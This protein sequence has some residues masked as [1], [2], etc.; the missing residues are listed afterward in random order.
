M[1]KLYLL[2]F[3]LLLHTQQQF[4]SHIPPLLDEL[5][6][7]LARHEQPLTAY[8]IS[9]LKACYAYD[10][11]GAVRN[12]W[13]LEIQN[14]E[15]ETLSF[16]LRSHGFNE[17]VVD[18][19]DPKFLS[20]LFQVVAATHAYPTPKGKE[21]INPLEAFIQKECNI[22]SFDRDIK[23]P[24]EIEQ[25]NP[26]SQGAGLRG[27]GSSWYINFFSWIYCL[28]TGK[29]RTDCTMNM[30][31]RDPLPSFMECNSHRAIDQEEVQP[32]IP[33]Q[34]ILH[35]MLSLNGDEK[36]ILTHKPSRGCVAISGDYDNHIPFPSHCNANPNMS[37][38]LYVSLY[39]SKKL[40]VKNIQPYSDRLIKTDSTPNTLFKNIFD[41]AQL[42]NR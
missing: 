4:T 28:I 37:K 2:L 12:S 17:H 31:T 36:I 5:A 40:G 11:C 9:Y 38:K 35:N 26:R 16:L 23:L 24:E 33:S 10:M 14:T 6:K 41:Q 13:A 18:N 39:S 27:A 21:T 19:N 34:D 25:W 32:W 1:K 7:K 30:E 3:A 42:T 22:S 8:D 20:N 15:N 29:K